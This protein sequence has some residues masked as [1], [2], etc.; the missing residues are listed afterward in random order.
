ML[1]KNYLMGFVTYLY[2]T[3]Q[4][5]FTIEIKIDK[6]NEISHNKL[7]F[8]ILPN[9]IIFHICDYIQVCKYYNS[10]ILQ[11]N[12]IALYNLMMTN[13]RNCSLTVPIFWNKYFEYS[14]H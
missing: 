5:I 2:F 6:P 12:K 3:I 14:N 10:S 7:S 13:K 8:D 9:E 4:K 1:F 11:D